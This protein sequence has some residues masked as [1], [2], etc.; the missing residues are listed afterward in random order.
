[1]NFLI[2]PIFQEKRLFCGW[3]NSAIDIIDEKTSLDEEGNIKKEKMCMQRMKNKNSLQFKKIYLFVWILIWLW[4][5]PIYKFIQMYRNN[6]QEVE[7]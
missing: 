3:A 4:Y 6:H 1:M 2:S 5:K 7:E